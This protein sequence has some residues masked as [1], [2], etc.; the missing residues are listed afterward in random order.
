MARKKDVVSLYDKVQTKL[1]NISQ[2]DNYKSLCAILE[3]PDYSGK[4]KVENKNQQLQY[5]KM[6]FSWVK[7]GEKFTK[8]TVLPKEKYL[9][10]LIDQYFKDACIYN[11][12]SF[13]NWYNQ[14]YGDNTCTLT[15][16]DLAL[17]MG[18][19]SIEFKKFHVSNYQYGLTLEEYVLEQRE[20][21]Y[22]FV[23]LPK[24]EIKENKKEKGEGSLA[25]RTQNIM[26]DYDIHVSANNNSKVDATLSATGDYSTSPITKAIEKKIASFDGDGIT[27]TQKVY[28]GGFID[29]EKLPFNADY[30]LIYEDNG[31]FYYPLENEDPLL[32]PYQE[33]SLNP[34]ELSLFVN[35]RGDIISK[36]GFRKFSQVILSK[37]EKEYQSIIFPEL[38]G[39]IGALFVYPAYYV[40]FSSS[41]IKSN[42][43]FYQS[44]IQNLFDVAKIKK[45]LEKANKENQKKIIELKKERQKKNTLDTRNKFV[46]KDGSEQYWEKDDIQTL[47]NN[48]LYEL[49]IYE[50]MNKDL[51]KIDT[52][53]FIPNVAENS[54]K[55][56]IWQELG[57]KSQAKKKAYQDK[58]Q[59]F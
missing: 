53:T 49:F 32:V 33:R 13:F 52:N 21:K 25:K 5:W 29:I 9:E 15:K 3:E 38:I 24:K 46:Q 50:K 55:I 51:L 27:V 2:V 44:K 47:E 18:L 56:S 23:A 35:I 48:N 58:F 1:K 36:M 54:Q 34:S 19:S 22:P 7:R 17:A 11:L 42:S 20:S 39:G 8:I 4:S 14:T 10:N 45:S 30:T 59:S 31:K 28:I 40:T 6:C 41:L 16:S 37:K 26:A 43:D 12:C 57:D